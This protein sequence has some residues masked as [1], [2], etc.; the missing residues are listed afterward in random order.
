MTNNNSQTQAPQ[1][2]VTV[3]VSS[4]LVRRSLTDDF[5]RSFSINDQE[6]RG[7]DFMDQSRN[8]LQEYLSSME[9]ETK[10]LVRDRIMV[11]RH[12]KDELDNY[13]GFAFLRLL[14]AREYSRSSRK[15][16]KT[17]KSASDRII[18]GSLLAQIPEALPGPG[19]APVGGGHASGVTATT[20]SDPFS[21]SHAMDD[22]HVDNSYELSTFKTDNNHNAAT[23][24]SIHREDGTSTPHFLTPRPHL[25]PGDHW[26]AETGTI[27]SVT[28]TELCLP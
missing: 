15:A 14:K 18:Y 17:V 23:A 1:V 8:L 21:D 2:G 19:V 25:S 22:M 3:N 16:F 9:P 11:A 26:L 10:K 4:H 20:R 13:N 7:D 12:V 5:R 6:E 28:P 24:P 27:S